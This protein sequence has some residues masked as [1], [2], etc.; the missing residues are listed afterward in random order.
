MQGD[1][2]VLYLFKTSGPTSST[3]TFSQM[4]LTTLRS[5]SVHLTMA[6]V[7]G[8]QCT[9]DVRVPLSNDRPAAV[10]VAVVV[11]VLG[12]VRRERVV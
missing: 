8:D 1:N 7:I 2:H 9:A 10:A 11:V 4:A 5:F 3:S 12:G 6:P